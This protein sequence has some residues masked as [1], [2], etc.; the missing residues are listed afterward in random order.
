MRAILFVLAW[1]TLFAVSYA[2][3][4]RET[5]APD[6]NV[7]YPS[8]HQASLDGERTYTE[9]FDIRKDLS[10]EDQAIIDEAEGFL[11]PDEL[12]KYCNDWH[13]DQ[14]VEADFALESAA[15]NVSSEVLA[16]KL[17][18]RQR[19]ADLDNRV[20]Y[21]HGRRLCAWVA[22]SSCGCITWL[23]SFFF[24]FVLSTLPI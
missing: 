11:S 8:S 10:P 20:A 3:E 15:G 6:P 16:R 14:D 21:T 7:P 24:F 18:I 2:Q 9:E 23:V 17:S 19:L 13:P 1:I 4:E 5:Y 12:Q 22:R